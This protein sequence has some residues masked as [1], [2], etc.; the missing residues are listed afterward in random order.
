M[1]RQLLLDLLFSTITLCNENGCP[2]AKDLSAILGLVLEVALE[3][4]EGKADP[5]AIIK[6]KCGVKSF[7]EMLQ[8]QYI[9]LLRDEA[10]CY[11]LFVL[12]AYK[13]LVVLDEIPQNLPM[14]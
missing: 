14:S 1:K 8:N 4:P 2:K 3:S 6:Y 11:Q 12:N 5:F 10:L 9:S 13:I 7:I